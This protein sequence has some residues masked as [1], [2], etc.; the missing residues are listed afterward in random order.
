MLI[1]LRT[2]PKTDAD[3]LQWT[4]AHAQHHL[5]IILAARAQLGI[6]FQQYVLDPVPEAA[7]Q[8]FLIN[9]QFSHNDMNGPIGATSMDLSTV[10]F[11]NENERAAWIEFHYAEHFVAGQAYGVDD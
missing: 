7:L 8:N 9:N 2:V 3:W 4:F 5:A 10:D 1:S 11:N 6:E